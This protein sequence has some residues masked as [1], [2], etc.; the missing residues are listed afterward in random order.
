MDCA[1]VKPNVNIDFLQYAQRLPAKRTIMHKMTA[2]AANTAKQPSLRVRYLRAFGRDE[3][4]SIIILTIVL[5]ITMLVL[6]GMAVDFMRYESRR[7][8]LQSV[9]DRAVL[10][11]SDREQEADPA[12]IVV[13]YFTKAGFD[14][15]IVGAPQVKTT[16]S[17]RSVS[18]ESELDVNTFYLRLIGI[19]QLEAPAA[20]A[21]AEGVSLAEI[22]L[23]LDISGSMRAVVNGAS[24]FELMQEAAIGFAETVLA[25]NIDPATGALYVGKD[26]VV[27]LNIIPYAGSV[28]PGPEMFNY[29]NAV[30]YDTFVN[31]G[32]DN[33]VPSP[34][35][36]HFPQVSSC[37]ELIGS[38]WTSPGLPATGRAQVPHFMYF[39]YQN[40]M[41][42]GWCP[43]DRSSIQ[44]A[45]A[46]P[47]DAR[48]FLNNIRMHDGTGTHFG[49]K[50]A[51]ALLDPST[52][53]A[54]AALS[55]QNVVPAEFST[56]P[57]PWKEADT[58]KI[59]VL[60]TDGDMTLQ[61]RP[62][63]PIDLRNLDVYNG[64]LSA[65]SSR[66][67]VLSSQSTNESRFRD[68]CT[69]AKASTRDVE[70]WTVAVEIDNSDVRNCASNPSMYFSTNAAGMKNVFQNI[71]QRISQ[72][73]LLQ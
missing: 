18:V 69:S 42:F 56:R 58:R 67:Y 57:A 12:A 38:D 29:L 14:G 51:L 33:I 60:M 1:C 5:L 24:R 49:M 62:N 65:H 55:A 2:D 4:G 31:A 8:L 35:D 37:I 13:D 53:P 64:H 23:V 39:K 63:D 36:V 43:Q 54:F 19:D 20:S 3:D 61:N 22:S 17:T 27:S 34:D 59:I 32:P 68:L 72:L 47:A 41:D 71:A 7:A 21:A 6:G 9:S 70:V 28:N 25:P 48:T 15:A 26:P 44:Y 52:Q 45:V 10:A 11:A 30:R 46:D 40:D 50:W 16:G 73:R 66:R